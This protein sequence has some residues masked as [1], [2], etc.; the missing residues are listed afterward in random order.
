MLKAIS[1]HRKGLGVVLAMTAMMGFTSYFVRVKFFKKDLQ[2][3]MQITAQKMNKKCPRMIDKITR[4]DRVEVK[5]G[6]QMHYHY[7]IISLSRA[8]VDTKKLAMAMK[9]IL[10]R[11][12]QQHRSLR[13]LVKNKVQLFHHYKDKDGKFL[14]K[15][16]LTT[17]DCFPKK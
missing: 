2:E 8:E 11:K 7:S 3:E 10:S 12:C 5:P 9:P 16:V 14:F 17:K 4:L 6:R 1:T 15:N 13:L